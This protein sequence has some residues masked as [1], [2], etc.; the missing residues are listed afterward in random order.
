MINRRKIGYPL[1]IWALMCLL[2]IPLAALFPTNMCSIIYLFLWLFTTII[3]GRILSVVSSVNKSFTNSPIVIGCFLLILFY[4]IKV[5]LL[6]F[7][8][9]GYGNLLVME[10]IGLFSTL[11]LWVGLLIFF[12]N[13]NIGVS[14]AFF[15]ISGFAMSI[16]SLLIYASGIGIMDWKLFTFLTPIFSLLYLMGFIISA[17]TCYRWIK[18][19]L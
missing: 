11:L 12:G 5:V 18:K 14:G 17:I 13:I 2:P 1:V 15:T 10:Y 4:G 7:E 3:F 19:R 8:I 16:P 6:A 9:L